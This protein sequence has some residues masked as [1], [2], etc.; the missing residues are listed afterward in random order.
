MK[1]GSLLING[2]LV[3]TAALTLF[4]LVWMV[5]VSFMPAGTSAMYP[6]P[7]FPA[8]PTFANYQELWT[9]AGMAQHLANSMLLATLATVLALTLN[10]AAGYAFAKIE[11]PGR[12]TVAKAMLAALVI[13]AQVAMLPLFLE[14]KALGLVDTYAGVLVPSLAG[15][16]SIFLV[17]QAALAIPNELIDAARIDGASEWTIYRRV[18]LPLMRPMLVTLGVFT[19][20]GSWNDFLWPLIVLNDSSRYT[21]PVALAALSREH[22]QDNE[23]MMAGSVVTVVPV[24]LLFLLLQRHYLAGLMAGAVKG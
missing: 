21:L 14:L 3:L 24:L 1:R 23:L 6:P 19:F 13:P 18:A 22:V 9:H 20:L 4:P 12:E 7:L 8:H 10:V 16:F 5:S 11:F 17:R 15:I 2:L